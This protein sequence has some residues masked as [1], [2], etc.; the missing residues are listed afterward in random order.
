MRLLLAVVLAAMAWITAQARITRIWDEN[1]SIVDTCVIWPL[2]QDCS[3]ISLEAC[4][5]MEGPSD[6]LGADRHS[7]NLTLLLAD[8]TR[9]VVT[10]GWGNTCLGD[11]TDSRYLS[12]DGVDT[13]SGGQVRLTSDVNLYSGD[14]SIVVEI[15]SPGDKAQ[16]YVGNDVMN[17][18][19]SVTLSSPVDSVSVGTGGKIELAFMA[20]E[21]RHEPRLDSGLDD[22]ELQQACAPGQ[23]APL[24]MWR[25]LDRDNDAASARPGGFYTLAIVADPARQGAYLLLYLD[26]ARVN[27]TAW[28]AGMIKGRLTPTR[29]IGRYRLEWRNAD[30]TILQDESMAILEGSDI[31][32]FTFPLHQSQMRFT[33]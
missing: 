10:I 27:S 2:P 7:W 6:C 4:V 28:K 33:R 23:E 20:I 3:G 14:N 15:D 19:G 18:A 1:R 29:F 26:G 24:G 5:A 32:T 9:R 30:K 31:L 13:P 8:G 11:F 12:V 17:Y 25:Y 22:Q 21:C 16:I